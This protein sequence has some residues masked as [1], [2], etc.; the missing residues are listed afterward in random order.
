MTASA[1][2]GLSTAMVSGKD[3]KSVL[4]TSIIELIQTTRR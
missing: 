3:M 4:L 2:F 1:V